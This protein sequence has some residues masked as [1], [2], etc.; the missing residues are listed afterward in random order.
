MRTHGGWSRATEQKSIRLIARREYEFGAGKF[1]YDFF[2]G[3]TAADGMPLAKFDTLVLRNGANDREFGMLRMEVAARMA[4]EAGFREVTPVRAATVFLNGEYYGFAW[5]HV[6]FNGH[7]LQDVYGTPTRD[8][9]IVG[10]GEWWLDTDDPDVRKDLEY[11]NS[12]AWRGLESDRVLAELEE[13]L[14]IDNFMFYYAYQMYMGNWDWPGNNLKRWRYAGP[15]YENMPPEADGRWRYIMFD[16]DWVLGL[17]GSNYN[18]PTFEEVL[19]GE[20]NSQ[21]LSALLERPDMLAKFAGIVCDIAAQVVTRENVVK[22][23]SAAYG[24]SE[25]E[26]DIAMERNII[27]SWVHKQWVLDNHKQMADYAANR[28][29]KVFM[30]FRERYRGDYMDM[31]TIEVKNG[32]AMLNTQPGTRARYFN[33]LTIPVSPILPKFSVFDH[34]L[35]NGT[36]VHEPDLLI[37]VEDA[38]LYQVELELVTREE[39]PI[40]IFHGAYSGRNGNGCSLTNRRDYA[41][42]TRGLFI[43][44]SP[45]LPFFW[46]MPDI[47]VQPGEVLELIGR[48]GATADDLLKV[49]LPFRVQR[50]AELYLTNADGIVLDSIKVAP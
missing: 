37:T 19:G 30:F 41:V 42:S 29:R 17:Y 33:A 28:N 40:F 44:D 26:L 2:P 43:S 34:W 35:V 5:V 12:F 25:R 7:Y 14:D 20:R 49:Q 4:R 38:V 27:A 18:Q 22:H 10:K 1:H 16:L 6:R 15:A 23:I 50:G 24:E 47:T 8:F 3:E 11:L 36:M 13:I 21:L 9:D 32:A 48:G 46:E 39:I 31:F 45:D